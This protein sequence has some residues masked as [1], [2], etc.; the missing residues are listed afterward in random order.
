MCALHSEWRVW[1]HEGVE[2]VVGIEPP[3]SA[4]WSHRLVVRGGC[5][6]ALRSAVEILVSS[7]VRPL[8]LDSDY[9]GSAVVYASIVRGWFGFYNFFHNFPFPHNSTLNLHGLLRML[10]GRFWYSGTR[11]LY[12]SV[13]VD[14]T[15]TGIKMTAPMPSFRFK[16]LR[17]HK[18][19]QAN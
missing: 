5:F 19:H 11:C 8:K 12:F 18:E 16:S 4:S 1:E 2:I 6:S 13:C 17:G 15:V 9:S 14:D 10:P 3:A 7:D